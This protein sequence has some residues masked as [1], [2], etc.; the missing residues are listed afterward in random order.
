MTTGGELFLRFGPFRV[1]IRS[2]ELFR[3]GRL[4]RLPPQAS[5]L[6][7]VL[8]SSPGELVSRD[9]IQRTL[10]G[11]DTF[12][13]F[14]HGI[15]K[16]INQVRAALGDDAEEPVY[17]QTVSRQGYRFLGTIEVDGSEPSERE[18][19]PYPG[20][21][22]F[23]EKDRLFFFGREGEVDALWNKIEKR[24]LMGLIGPSGAGKSSFLRAG[25]LPSRPKGWRVVFLT[26]GSAPSSSLAR[27]MLTE[28]SESGR[29]EQTLVVVD[30]FEE[31][32]TLNPLEVQKE[33]AEA[34]G[35]LAAEEDNKVHVLLSMRDDFL[36]RCHEHERL[37]PVFFDLTPL[38]PPKGQALRRAL[39]EPALV[40]GYG[41]ESDELVAEM[42]GEVESERGALPLLAFSAARLWEQRDRQRKLL[43]RLAFEENGRVGGALAK[44][45]E[46]VLEGIGPTRL[47]LA[48]E[49]FRNLV[50]AQGTRSSRK[51]EDLLSIFP[52]EGDRLAAEHVVREL[53]AA[54]LLTS[55]YGQAETNE[56]W[57]EIVHESL[58]SAW[59]R[60]V[61]WQTQDADSAQL[62][63]QLRQTAQ[64][65]QDRG[66]PDDLLWTGS[67]YRE[68]SVWREHYPGGLS[69]TEHAFAE[70]ATRLAGRRRRT[71][72][73]AIGALLAAA[74]A[75]SAVVI[76]FWRDAEREALRAEASKLLAFGEARLREDPTEALAFATASLELADTEEARV[77]AMKAL[78]E[79]PPAFELIADSQAARW[80]AFSPHGK[81]LA[82]TGHATDA[83]VWSEDGQGPIVLP[84]H[85]T[86]PR[87][88]NL[89]YW[90]SN[91]LLVTGSDRMVGSRV[92]LW[93][94]P[95]GRS[96]RTINFGQPSSW[97][98][99][100][101]LLLAETLET[102]SVAHPGIGVLRSWKLPNGEPVFLGRINWKE[103]GTLQTFFLPNGTSW[104]YAKDR[105]LYSRP[106]PIG[107]GPDRVVA[108]LNAE[109]ADFSLADGP[110][111]LAPADRSGETHVWSFTHHGPTEESVLRQAD[112]LPYAMPPDHAGRWFNSYPNKDHQ[113]HVWD[114]KAWPAARPLALR[115]SGSWY[116]AL[117]RFHPNGDWVVA[118]TGSFTRLT[119]WPLA[120]KYPSVVEGYTGFV[121]PLAFS[122]DGKWLATS[123]GGRE[124]RLWPLPGSGVNEVK[125]LSLPG[126][127]LVNSVAFD[128]KGTFLFVAGNQD[129]AWVVPLD[130][131]AA[132]S[133]LHGFSEDTLLMAGAISPSARFVATAF[134]YGQGEKTLR[135]WN[136][137]TGELR[138]FELPHVALSEATTGYERGIGSLAFAD[139]SILYTAGDGGFRRW[140]LATGLS[141]ML[142]AAPPGYGGRGSINA[143]RGVAIT[144]ETRWGL[145]RDCTRSLVHDLRTGT[146]RPLTDFG[147]CGTWNHDA[148]A[149]DASGT[150]AATGSLDG[151]VRVGRLSGA[152]PHLLVGHRGSIDRIAISPDLRW[153]ATTGEDNTMRLWPMPDLSKPP[154]HT[155]PHDALL[156]K[157]RSLTNFRAVRDSSSSTGWKVE[158]GPF[159]GWKAVPTW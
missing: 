116:G 148:V 24:R 147:E 157:L 144:Y 51:I 108:Q 114:L 62:R 159:P 31:L 86:S 52:R 124:L 25:L 139:D 11:D 102:G 77:F 99:G 80:P 123:W 83:L 37:A 68:F 95:E 85:D 96:V 152:E 93:S 156:A 120:R 79:A 149:L 58:L 115:R 50:T 18:A 39:V 91:D 72:R 27:A 30:A 110:D 13:D 9:E 133:R 146:S 81:W 70:A 113:V 60:L 28:T 92:Y 106:L 2:G 12:V 54:R 128:R 132:P 126:S 64:V 6:L 145:W 40:C 154:L 29:S 141:E 21:S 107:S 131:S 121:R 103:L 66:R 111:R 101:G 104:L 158:V 117:S 56:T 125:T 142:A 23:T 69:A 73:I 57:V 135:I 17:V 94:L 53:I 22:T 75:G 4:V 44:H 42:L 118:S 136:L 100:P 84:G 43:T 3:E 112:P 140:D 26:P 38:G 122:P 71:R 45:A 34:I 19:S 63:D 155:L 55:Y 87:G 150:V 1:D 14:E 98:V 8:V 16:C 137:E 48:R 20:L 138:Q 49:V 153:V 78:W 5:K 130:G 88:P 10:W 143:E 65:W 41:F 33:F 76:S 105:D 61:R 129:R 15:N 119:F 109:P 46:A 134:W 36:F 67:S 82:S 151:I 59:P 127:A 32:F 47:P 89:A 97:Q 90:A 74:L 35:R 7:R